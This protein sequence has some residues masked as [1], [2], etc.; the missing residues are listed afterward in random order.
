[1]LAER[2]RKVYTKLCILIWGDRLARRKVNAVKHVVFALLPCG[3]S[4]SYKLGWLRYRFGNFTLSYAAVI[5]RYNMPVFGHGGFCKGDNVGRCLD[6]LIAQI[7][8]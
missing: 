8:L 3:E 7:P 1:M 5:L 2:V 4:N 6:Y